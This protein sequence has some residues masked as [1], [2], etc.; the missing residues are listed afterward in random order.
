MAAILLDWKAAPNPNAQALDGPTPF[1]TAVDFGSRDVIKNLIKHGAQTHPMRYTIMVKCHFTGEALSSSRIPAVGSRSGFQANRRERMHAAL[2]YAVQAG[3]DPA[4][5][6]IPL[7]Q[8]GADP[9]IAA[10]DGWT[11]L[12]RAINRM[13][14]PA[15]YSEAVLKTLLNTSVA[16]VN[17]LSTIPSGDTTPLMLAIKVRSQRAIQLFTDHGA[18]ITIPVERDGH[19]I[20]PVLRAAACHRP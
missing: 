20:T 5:A 6:V 8:R 3:H 15:D 7:L 12:L 4:L 16:N 19:R 18:D 2:H 17:R 11:P 14:G 9:N 10:A 13:T 1:H